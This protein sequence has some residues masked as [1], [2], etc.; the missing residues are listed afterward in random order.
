MHSRTTLIFTI[1]IL[2][3]VQT[4]FALV[5]QNPGFD[6]QLTGP[7]GYM[8][9]RRVMQLYETGNWYDS[10]ELRTNAPF[11]EQLHWTRPLDSIL[12]AGA[13]IGSAAT[14]FPRSLLAWG[15]AVGPATLLLL[16]PIWSWGTR[17]LLSPSGFA[18]SFAVLVLLPVLNTVFLLGRPDHHGL[19][20]LSFLSMIAIFFRLAAGRSHQRAALAAGVIAGTALWISVEALVAATYFGTALALLWVWR[21]ESYGRHISSYL[22]GLLVAVT[23]ALAI[24]RPPEQWL[25]PFYERISFV[26]WFLASA[27]VATWFS[28][29][30][31]SRRLPIAHARWRRIA[32]LVT[33]GLLTTLA[34]AILFPKFFQGPLVDFRSPVFDAWLR[35]N[36]E[37]R[38]NWPIDRSSLD[39]FLINMGPAIIALGYMGLHWKSASAERR[40]VFA[41][42][43]LGFAVYLPLALYQVRWT[44]YVQGLTLL[45]FVI[46][47]TGVWRW[48]GAV[49]F[50]GQA[51]P[52]RSLVAAVIVTGPF[53]ASA[54]VAGTGTGSASTQFVANNGPYRNCDRIGISEYLSRTHQ[55][56]ASD[57]ILFTYSFWG[58]EIVWRTPYSVVGAPYGN[59]QSLSDTEILFKAPSDVVAAKVI[60]RRGIDLIL[61]CTVYFE[62]RKYAAG[63]STFFNRL[64]GDPP[65]WLAPV[66]LPAHLAPTFRLY[67]VQPEKL[68]R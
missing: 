7:D 51:F 13:W 2:C 18:L 15:A 16:V 65:A 3:L 68:P 1:L 22:V 55:G 9:L 52:L 17:S 45:P 54:F 48:Q 62:N 67:R 40:N 35:D 63:G 38:P 33:A 60:D 32:V 5:T 28:A 41:I 64:T 44:S 57:D 53:I 49:R 61:I 19:L 10:F 34:V 43:L 4:A 50:A 66:G 42:L 14:E 24:E 29:N 6:G 11:G 31:L 8:R 47:L 27:L 30:A 59:T 25:S 23:I 12:F 46:A 37:V 39:L 58:S 56:G 36:T 20:A 21:G 26:H